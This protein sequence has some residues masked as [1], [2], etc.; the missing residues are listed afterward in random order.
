LHADRHPPAIDDAA[1]HLHRDAAAVLRHE[2]DVEGPQL[3]GEILLHRCPVLGRH[4]V[5]DPQP[6]RLVAGVSGDALAGP[7]HPGDPALQVVRIDDVAGI[8]HQLAVVRL[9]HL[10]DGSRL[11]TRREAKDGTPA[12]T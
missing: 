8:L 1:L 10:D 2:L 5:P 12:R 7:V 3:G 11:R 6:Q 4:Q 9:L